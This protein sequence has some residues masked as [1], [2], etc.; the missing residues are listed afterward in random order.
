MERIVYRK[1]LDVHKNGVQ[2]MLQGFETADRISRRIEITLMA[3]GDAIDLPLEQITA[4]MYVT[5]P[6]A[7]EPSINACTIK[8][9]TIIYDVLPITV[10]G[11]T[12]MQL[13]LIETDIKGA[14]S[15]IATPKF[16]VEVSESNANDEGATQTTQFT[17]LEHA[18]AN[19]NS[20]YAKRLLRIELDVDCMFRAYYADGTVYETDILK[21]LFH[22]G[23]ALLSQ[24]YARGGTGVR[25]GE[26]TDNS[27]YYS[28][29]SKSASKEAETVREESA[30]ILT[31]VQKHGVYTA[32]SVDF[33]TGEVKY[34]S[35]KYKFNINKE[36]GE[37]DAIGEAYTPEETVDLV[38]TEWLNSKETDIK[39]LKQ[40]YIVE[41]YV[42]ERWTV[43]KWS[44]GLCELWKKAINN[45]SKTYEGDT[46]TYARSVEY[47]PFALCGS[48]YDQFASCHMNA[49]PYTTFYPDTHI[50]A[51]ILPSMDG[52]EMYVVDD[53]SYRVSIY[54]VGRWK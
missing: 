44:S 41:S 20:V 43:R 6:G 45:F 18:I 29:V 21:E 7:T 10:G 48:H 14:R 49:E 36:T 40:D 38:V 2:F 24:S 31:E 8:D 53:G 46:H 28:Q 30:E 52:I 47:F 25:T 1:T 37:L 15:V 51:D 13:K 39:N 33:A 35:P 5:T 4:I 23:E 22:K 3:S 19:A 12:E 9:N 34:I 54:V 11:I 17:A 26:D 50:T 27:M 16:A 32:F 42:Q